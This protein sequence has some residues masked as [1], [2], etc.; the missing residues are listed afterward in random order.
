MVQKSGVFSL[1]ITGCGLNANY[2]VQNLNEKKK[3]QI[4]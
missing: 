3:F 1:A 4:I 2:F